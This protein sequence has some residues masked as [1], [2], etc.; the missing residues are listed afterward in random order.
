MPFEESVV[1]VIER[2]T[3][4]FYGKYRGLVA[5]N[6]DESRQ[7]RIKA[8]V[9]EVLGVTPS[10]FALP[11]TPYA[12]VQAGLFTVPMVGSGVW[13][14]FEAGDVTRPIWS[15]CW[16][17]SA[18][19]PLNESGDASTFVNKVLRTDTG[20]MLAFNDAA[21]TITMTDKTGLNV[22]SMA[23]GRIKV[24]GKTVVTL[25]APLIK[26][27]ETATHPAVFGDDLLGYLGELV[28]MFN[29]HMHP[30]EFLVSPTNVVT[31]APPMPSMRPPSPSLLS[32]K[33][34]LE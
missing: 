34:L 12:G 15:G 2:Q 13:I 19:V 27:G 24:T 23:V 25:E 3:D 7:G 9:P 4:R 22:I 28:T 18:E 32:Q 20:L 21:Q 30:G 16:W 26:H 17:G 5:I 10:T 29:M 31:P 14:E 6:V 33:S 1:R 11:C 8:I